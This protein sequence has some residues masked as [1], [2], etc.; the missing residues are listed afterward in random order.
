MSYLEAGSSGGDDRE[1]RTVVFLHGW[2][3]SHRAYRGAV[4]R[5]AAMGVRVLAPAMPGFSGSAGLPGEECTLEGYAEWVIAFLDELGVDEPVLLVG[6]SFGGGV[7]I[8]VAHDHP[9]RVGALVLVN[10]IGGA[11]WADDGELQ[12]PITDRPI[13]DW[14]LH[15]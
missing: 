5:L 6:H 8:K 2:G 4:K 15:L 13:W 12:R 3:L 11:V 10:S 14:G 9:G 1:T 7:S